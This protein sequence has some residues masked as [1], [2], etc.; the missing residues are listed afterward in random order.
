MKVGADLHIIIGGNKKVD[1]EEVSTTQ[2]VKIDTTKEIVYELK[3]INY[4]RVFHSCQLLT[5][6]K[7]LVS[8]G[9]PKKR[10]DP[11]Q[12]LPDELYD[13]EFQDVEVLK[14]ENSVGR[15]QHSLARIGERLL[16]LGGTDASG[17]V[18]SKIKEF[19]PTTNS[20]KELPQE[21]HSSDTTQLTITPIPAAAVDCPPDC[22][23]GVKKTS[24]IF[25]GSDVEVKRV[26]LLILKPLHRTAVFP[27]SG[28]F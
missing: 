6:T 9:L 13:I 23:C 4:G 15:V 17:D 18:P 21:L 7:I 3:S 28:F 20:W 24:R 10:G 14:Q 8:G 26:M 12:I 1:E 5:S 22:I 19:D 11:S 27:G 2:V 16:A 25:G